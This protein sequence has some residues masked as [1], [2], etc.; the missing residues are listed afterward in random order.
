MRQLHAGERFVVLG[1][2]GSR[3]EEDG[4]EGILGSFFGA[5]ML[6]TSRFCSEPHTGSASVFP[7]L[8]AR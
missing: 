4:V 7:T 3:S 1:K 6:K 8:R 2:N 5:A